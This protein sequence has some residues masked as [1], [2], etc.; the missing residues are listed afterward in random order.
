[1]R[2]LT[3]FGARASGGFTL[4]ELMVVVLVITILTVIAAPSYT[5]QVRK[6]RRTE[7]KSVLLDL[8]AREERYM[9]TNGVYASDASVLGMSA[10]GSVGSNYY[11]IAAPTVSA[12][13]L[14]SVGATA[15]PPGFT[16]TATA[17][18]SQAKDTQCST[19]TVNQTGLQTSQTSSSA[20]STGCW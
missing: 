13:S 14:S 17:V 6:S 18:N 20:T 2:K 5:Q 19:F 3:N 9:A 8:A 12:A 11:T 1:M 16:I 10:W 15:T 4:I 7:A